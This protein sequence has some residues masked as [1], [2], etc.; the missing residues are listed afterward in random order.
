MANDDISQSSLIL[1]PPLTGPLR[2]KLQALLLEKVVR[3]VPAQESSWKALIVDRA[4][5]RI[6]SATLHLNELVNEGVSIIELLDF[7]REPLPSVPAVYFLT[8][9]A[10]TVELLANEPLNQ[11][12]S[13]RIFFT[14]PL[15]DFLLSVVKKRGKFITRVKQFVELNV[16]FLALE[17]RLFSLD[18]P[19]SSLPQIHAPDIP[20]EKVREELAEVR[21]RLSEVC[22]LLAPHLSWNVRSD[23]T[24]F[25]ARTLASL[26]REELDI[27]TAYSST[28]SVPSTSDSVSSGP[29]QP[30]NA[31]L[32]I[33]DRASDLASPLAHEF[34][35]QAMAHDLLPLNYRKPGGAQIEID[36]EKTQGKKFVQLDDE[37]KDPIWGSIRWMFI[38]HAL[39]DAQ[40]AFRQFVENDAAFKIRGKTTD[41]LDIKEMSAAV[42]ALPLSQMKADKHALHITA[43][44]SCLDTCSQ[45]SLT[46]L[47]L[48]E[49]DLLIGRSSDG[50]KIKS[51]V[52]VETIMTTLTDERIPLDHRLR[53]LMIALVVSHGLPGLGGETSLFSSSLT[54]RSRLTRADLMSVLSLNA[55]MS[56]SVEGLERLLH[57]VKEGVDRIQNRANPHLSG[58]DGMTS[59]LWQRYAARQAAKQAKREKAARRKRHG[60][61]SE[62][63]LRY[64]VARYIPPL[65]SVMMDLVDNELDEM[66]FPSADTLSVEAIISSMGNS[67]LD[68]P[69]KE[70]RSKSSRH[71]PSGQKIKRAF[72]RSEGDKKSEDEEGDGDC[73]LDEERPRH[74]DPDH[75]YVVFVFGGLCYSEVRSMYEVC[76]KRGANIIIGG[77]AILTPNT[78]K[79]NMAAVADS[80]IRVQAMLPPLPLE[81]A[82]KK[83]PVK[84]P[85]SLSADVAGEDSDAGLTM[86]DIDEEFERDRQNGEVEVVTGYKKSRGLRI[87]GRRKK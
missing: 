30:T 42:R 61:Q 12:K 84:K 81:L 83:V 85:A 64:D 52:M 47:A 68:E 46:D 65:R 74:A 3:S 2:S 1:T 44:R 76:S 72:G 34:T 70:E 86:D 55:E 17:S 78:F 63:D 5:L 54:F 25:T 22:K 11:Y 79:R 26:L 29:K 23:A 24:S 21:D 66:F 33:I 77:S 35:Y 36:D 80:I 28:A 43:T 59:K 20:S 69:E 56:A 39:R 53:L 49:Q 75:L 32:L 62:D 9:C 48:V 6:L 73:S 58:G 4:A 31:T 57:V 7:R 60:L 15:S 82:E 8:P 10:E 38:Q 19:A 14:S 71:F 87:F 41:Q 13:Y 40:E 16:R 50:A 51:D 37:D 27:S 67:A 18:R 45:L